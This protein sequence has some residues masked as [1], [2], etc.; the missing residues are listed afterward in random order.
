MKNS[1]STRSRNW[2]L[3]WAWVAGLSLIYLLPLLTLHGAVDIFLKINGIE[4]ESQDSEHAKEIDVLAWSWGAGTPAGF[5]G[6]GSVPMAGKTY[7]Q[8]LSVSK[9]VDKASPP[10]LL[11]MVQGKVIDEATLTVRK[12]G[13]TPIEYLEINL[14]DLLVTS[15]ATGGSGGD[16]RL[17]ENVTFF[18]GFVSET[19]FITDQD[20]KTINESSVYYD[21]AMETGGPGTGPTPI[22]PNTAPTLSAI[23]DTSTLEDTAKVV[24][25]TIGDTETAAGALTVTRGS[26]NQTLVPTGN[27]V[28]GGSGFNRSVTITPALNATGTATI[29]LIVTD[30]G[31]LTA[32]RSFLLTVDAVNDAPTLTAVASQTTNQDVPI[33]VSVT[34][35]D[36][37]SSVD[38]I[39]VTGSA[40]PGGILASA[41]DLTGSGSLRFIRLTPVANSSGDTTVTLTASDGADSSQTSFSLTV[42]S[43]SGPN[44]IVLDGNS[45]SIPVSLPENSATNTELGLLEP[46]DAPGTNH[47]LALLDDAGGR[48]KLGGEGGDLLMVADGALLDFETAPS[49]T[50]L[51]KATDLS[52]GTRTRTDA[53]TINMTNVNEVPVIQP[54][55]ILAEVTPETDTPLMGI[56]ITDADLASGSPVFVVTFAATSGTLFLDSSGVLSGRVT[57]NNTPS[58]SVTAP[59]GDIRN[60]LTATGLRYHGNTDFQGTET[61]TITANDQ[62]ATG[63][64]GPQSATISPTFSVA[65]TSFTGWQF[66]RFDAAERANP[67]VSGPY[68]HGDRDGVP[69]LVEYGLGSD[70]RSDSSGPQNVIEPIQVQAG[71]S[72]YPAIRF[73]RRISDPTLAI[74]VEV[75]TTL[76]DWQSG[77]GHTVEENI[78]PIDADFEMVTVRSTLLKSD[79]AVQQMR[80]RFTILSPS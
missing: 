78:T 80:I 36:V 28:L 55:I 52:D 22:T 56:S 17:I 59:I 6:L 50:V 77:T 42:N 49:H 21:V 3:P 26:N 9:F 8:D 25:F 46:I 73:R 76:T 15:L 18:S 16:E 57:G 48:F 13:A 29:T 40:S 66:T 71:P 75:A 45:A 39:T 74:V 33:H 63:A 60:V 35:A 69:N 7:V 67:A 58:L 61:L 72:S 53:F 20:G 43:A 11:R 70:P 24:P 65:F 68:G 2:R 31:G 37:D 4:G 27:I 38:A 41:A 51:V 30:G 19:Y 34:V 79:Q 1:S 54:P 32:T 64:G 14:K 12:A 44:A 10:L 62:G 23:A 47:S 5:S